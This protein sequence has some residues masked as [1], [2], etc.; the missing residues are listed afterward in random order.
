MAMQ[1]HPDIGVWE[2]SLYVSQ[3]GRRSGRDYTGVAGL[4]KGMLF[5]P[6][7]E[8]HSTLRRLWRQGLDLLAPAFEPAI[9]AAAMDSKFR[10]LRAAGR[11][12]AM[13]SL[14]RA[15]PTAVMAGAL[16]LA[17]SCVSAIRRASASV[18]AVYQRG[19]SLRQ[20]DAIDEDARLAQSEIMGELA[21]ARQEPRMGLS[22]LL[23]LM[24]AHFDD[25]AL[26]DYVSFFVLASVETLT[27]LFGSMTLLLLSH[28][29]QWQKLLANP[30]LT[31]PCVEEAIR[32]AGPMRRMAPRIAHKDVTLAGVIIPAGATITAELEQAHHDPAAFVQPE[33]FDITRTGPPNMGFGV[34][35]HACLGVSVARLEAR[36][37][38]QALR[39]AGPITLLDENPVWEDHPSFRRLVTLELKFS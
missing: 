8:D 27:G 13:E 26:A 20:L 39:T 22:R 9:M 2:P 24:G 10:E 17:P 6:N 4:L 21:R 14:C 31:A 19:V 1:R 3:L 15:I 36:Q 38:L 32:F 18:F 34:G 28:P 25:R 33:T 11:I 29:D 23:T 37:Y 12:E 35:A 30:A 16:G 7:P 5:Y